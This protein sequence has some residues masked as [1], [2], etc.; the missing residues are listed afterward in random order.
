MAKYTMLYID[1]VSKGGAIPAIFSEI[2]NFE[3]LF[4]QR[5]ADKE[6]GFETPA[7]F[8]LKLESRAN[9]I[10]PTY[11]LKIDLLASAWEKMADNPSK[12][13]VFGVQ[14]TSTTDLPIDST[15]AEPNTIN[16]M[17]EHINREYGA[18]DDGV[19]RQIEFYNREIKPLITKL[20]DEF[21]GLFMKVY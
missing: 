14:K 18:D 16:E 17:D 7:L 10:I 9:E 4:L 2:E 21:S 19:M 8:A 12:Y 15:D 3:D 6:L 5:Y 20:L 1:Y 13:Y 11:K